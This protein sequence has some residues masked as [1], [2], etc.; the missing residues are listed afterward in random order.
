MIDGFK[1]GTVVTAK[2]SVPEPSSLLLGTGLVAIL[3]PL[4]RRLF[5]SPSLARCA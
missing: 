1:P 3:G 5:R 2:P 4:R